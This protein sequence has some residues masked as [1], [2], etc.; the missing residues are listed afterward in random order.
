MQIEE[1]R[2]ALAELTTDEAE[3]T[4]LLGEQNS[5]IQ[6]LKDGGSRD[7]AQLA[8][9]EAK[10][11]ALTTMLGEQRAHISSAQAR[12]AS[13]EAA[14]V[15]GEQV[16]QLRTRV[17]GLLVR[18]QET[19]RLLLELGKILADQIEKITTTRAAW[20]AELDDAQMETHRVFGLVHP[21]Q[22]NSTTSAK[23]AWS[24]A[25]AEIGEGAAETLTQSPFSKFVPGMGQLYT[26][27]QAAAGSQNELTSIY[28]A[29]RPMRDYLDRPVTLT[30][31]QVLEEQNYKA[32]Y[33]LNGGE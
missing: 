23:N 25:F 8:N 13:L 4:R 30:I 6:A 2:T 11:S 10:R 27:P 12:L 29:M 16:N 15:K 18:R 21:S 1:A 31:A 5:S 3:L 33:G 20:A 32:P 7:F 19:D 22:S 24:A 28:A 14:K 26:R 9:L 17:Q